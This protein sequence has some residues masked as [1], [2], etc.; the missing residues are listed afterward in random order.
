MVARKS[1]SRRAPK[2]PRKNANY[3][4]KK[5]D[6]NKI[7][8]ITIFLMIVIVALYCVSSGFPY[9]DSV[10]ITITIPLLLI[11]F[12]AQHQITKQLKTN[13][14]NAKRVSILGA[15]IF[16]MIALQ[17]AWPIFMPRISVEDTNQLSGVVYTDKNQYQIVQEAV[18]KVNPP[19]FPLFKSRNYPIADNLTAVYKYH[20]SNLDIIDSRNGRDI[21]ITLKRVTGWSFD[22]LSGKIIY[23]S[24]KPFRYPQF[25]RYDMNTNISDL[26][27]VPK[28]Y[29]YELYPEYYLTTSIPIENKND[30]PV[31][32]FDLTLSIQNNTPA[33]NDFK[34]WVDDGFCVD[35]Y[36]NTLN[37]NLSDWSEWR[38]A[39][40]TSK[41]KIRGIPRN[42]FDAP[43]IPVQVHYIS[44]M[45][46]ETKNLTI[47]FK[48]IICGDD[49][50]DSPSYKSYNISGKV[51][52]H[53]DQP[54]R[55]DSN[56][57]II[58]VKNMNTTKVGSTYSLAI[59]TSAYQ[60]DISGLPNGYTPGDI[61]QI[62]VCRNA[63]SC[64]ESKNITIDIAKGY[65]EVNFEI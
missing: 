5:T 55:P 14:F 38:T 19:L 63:Q 8:N 30:F 58:L 28:I 59:P 12:Y 52:S 3:K 21:K 50:K 7:G 4:E 51:K 26:I 32:L 17:A 31:E 57:F 48:E 29:D 37:A 47:G 27:K 33:W 60:Y 34:T 41:R 35:P 44:L 18:V 43:T 20:S 64:I 36:Y 9:I 45:P 15:F 23:Q 42:M 22:E 65:D 1:K 54:Y 11:I 39:D 56:Y 2:K 13:G 53:E 16:G 10:I 6:S 25:I 24:D 49:I 61:I 46:N 62:S 40:I